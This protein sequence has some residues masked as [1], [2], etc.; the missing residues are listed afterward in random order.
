MTESASFELRLG[1]TISDP[2]ASDESF[3]MLRYTFK[4]ESISKRPGRLWRT[5]GKSD[6]E[7]KYKTLAAFEGDAGEAK[8]VQRFSGSFTAQKESINECVVVVQGG[9]AILH[10]L[11]G[12]TKLNHL[13]GSNAPKDFPTSCP[14]PLPEGHKRK[15]QQSEGVS[16]SDGAGGAG[17]RN[18]KPVHDASLSSE[19]ESSDDSDSSEGE[20]YVCCPVPS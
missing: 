11:S 1:K 15:L 16:D 8:S 19:D 4:P 6:G 10:R 12:S 5:K 7:Q 20:S 3:E 17:S 13:P 9:K 14:A 2:S 18:V